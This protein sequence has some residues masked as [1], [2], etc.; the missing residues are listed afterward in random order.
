LVS[1]RKPGKAELEAYQSIVLGRRVD[2]FIIVRTRLQDSRIEYLQKADFPFAVFGRVK[3]NDDFYYVDE[4]SE[5]GMALIVD[6]LLSLGHKRFGVI[7]P[8][9]NLMFTQF[10]MSGIQARLAE[11]GLEL[12]DEMVYFGDLTQ[13]CGYQLAK[14]LIDHPSPPTAIIACNDLMAFGAMSAVQ[15]RGLQ[16]G[17]DI[18]VTGFD[19]IPMSEYT[20][21]PLTTLHQPIY[22]IG[23]KLSEMLIKTIRG[24][25]LDR[26]KEI[27]KPALVIRQSSGLAKV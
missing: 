10:R 18:S 27:L 3:G 19:D 8:P 15:E 7:T 11:A 2:G 20:H 12:D 26:R 14:K 24:E 13:S 6:H 4:D 16:V 9:E 21:P 22:Q 17:E 25:E 1:T 23:V 5:Q